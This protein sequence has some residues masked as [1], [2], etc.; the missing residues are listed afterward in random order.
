M[1]KRGRKVVPKTQ[2]EISKGMHTPY[3]KEAGNP[4]NA[5]YQI[6]NRSNQVSFKGDT[7][8]PFSV[9]LEDIDSTILY[10]RYVCCS[11]S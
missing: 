10:K 4:N 8:K 1:S 6:N 5:A 7:V 3:S 9:G 2:K 11:C